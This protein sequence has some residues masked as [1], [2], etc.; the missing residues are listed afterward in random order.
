[1]SEAAPEVPSP[2]SED[3]MDAVRALAGELMKL[4]G[5]AVALVEAGRNVDLASLDSQ[6]GLLCAKTLDLPPDD[7]R[8]V[9]PRLIAL[10]GSVEALSRAIAARATPP[11]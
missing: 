11:R 8:R 5:V 3:P 9:R 4:V 10:S 7:G 1:M 6:V 2:D